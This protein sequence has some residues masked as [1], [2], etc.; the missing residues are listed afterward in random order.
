[1]I[2]SRIRK[3]IRI[4]TAEGSERIAAYKQ[5]SM[6]GWSVVVSAETAE[7]YAPVKKIGCISLLVSGSILL[8]VSVVIFLLARSVMKPLKKIIRGMTGVSDQVASASGQIATM[9]Q[10]LAQ[11]TSEQAT[12]LE[13]S[14]ASL[15]E[16][17][18]MTRKNADNSKAARQFI[19]KEAIPNLQILEKD[20][21]GADSHEVSPESW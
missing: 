18:S 8:V 15:E 5:S 7:L 3:G 16:T 20:G 9:G 10:R 6:T 19:K 4:C 11:G 13:V 12:S 1:M 17:A 2:L 21:T 14:S